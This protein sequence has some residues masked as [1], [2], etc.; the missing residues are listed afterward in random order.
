MDGCLGTIEQVRYS[1]P[2]RYQAKH[3]MIR[4][5]VEADIPRL[6]EMGSRS[7][8]EGAY[9]DLVGDNPEQTGKLAVEVMKKGIILVAEEKGILTGVLAFILFPHYFSGE[10]TAG[11]V[12]W[13]VEPEYRQSFTALCLLRAAERMARGFGAKRMQFT[14]PTAAVGKAYESL[15]YQQVEVTFQKTL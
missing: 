10:L 13:Y 6:T 5:A 12:I 8:R 15:R 3:P 11:E 1:V 2:L 9:K 14:A 7:L 4:E